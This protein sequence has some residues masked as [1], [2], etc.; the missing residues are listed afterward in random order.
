MNLRT[1][2]LTSPSVKGSEGRKVRDCYFVPMHPLLFPS[3]PAVQHT[4]AH[5]SW[6]VS[7][8]I[9]A[10]LVCT[11]V[12]TAHVWRCGRCKWAIWKGERASMWH[13]R[14]AAGGRSAG[15][16][17]AGPDDRPRLS[18]FS[19]PRPPYPAFQPP[20]SAPSSSD[21]ADHARRVPIDLRLPLALRLARFCTGTDASEPTRR[22]DKPRPPGLRLQCSHV[23]AVILL[24][25]LL[26]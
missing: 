21:G 11:Y 12:W 14:F 10:C 23:A 16:P 17:G 4:L 2:P 25:S 9:N 19:C 3:Q 6:S 1:R 24:P 13:L 8:V 15:G 7:D 22:R 18:S 20:S 26:A 5:E